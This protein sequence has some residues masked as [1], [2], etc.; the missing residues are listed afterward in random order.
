MHHL[1]IDAPDDVLVP[2]S[3]CTFIPSRTLKGGSMTNEEEGASEG[4]REH[5]GAGHDA[6]AD[7]HADANADANANAPDAQPPDFPMAMIGGA[8]E[9]AGGLA[10]WDY[11]LTNSA[12]TAIREAR[13]RPRTYKSTKPCY[14]AAKAFYAWLRANGAS[15]KR[16][17]A[18]H[19]PVDIPAALDAHLTSLLRRGRITAEDKNKFLARLREVDAVEVTT[20]VE[21]FIVR[22]DKRTPRRYVCHQQVNVKPNEHQVKARIVI[23]TRAAPMAAGKPDGI[24][25]LLRPFE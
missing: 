22:S 3:R 25:K 14:A 12:G 2:T 13:G 4:E 11:V 1:I 15:W 5:T 21:I 16:D 23:E 17:R 18:R 9:G 8:G 24:V 10:R 19:T 6:H 7:A 20:A